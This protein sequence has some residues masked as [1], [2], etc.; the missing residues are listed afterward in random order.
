M[1][2]AIAQYVDIA[3]SPISER[4]Q[5]INRLVAGGYE[6]HLNFSPIIIYGGEQWRHDWVETWREIDDTLTPEAK[7]Q[8]ACEI[9]FL[10][11]S[12]DLHET[13]LQWNPKGETFLWSPEIQQPK[14]SK[15][16]VLTYDYQLKRQELDRFSHGLKKYLPYC[17]IRYAF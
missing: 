1:P 3:T 5:S 7:A 16:D 14:R 17:T 4:I 13:N 8:L 6:V 11:H 2:Q 9:F 10:T 15:P 12:T